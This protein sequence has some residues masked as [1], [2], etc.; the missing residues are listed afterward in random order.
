M[1]LKFNH[2]EEVGRFASLKHKAEQ[3]SRLTLVFARNGYGKSTLCAILRSASEEAPNYI[4]ARR[5]LDAKKETRI[6]SSWASG[7][8]VS[9][10]AGKWNSCPGKVY[11]FDQE[12]VFQNLHVGDSVTREN[13][14]SLLPVVLGAKG[15]EL[16]QKIIELD[17]EQRDLDAALKKHGAV[18]RAKCPVVAQSDLSSFC[19][20]E[21]PADIVTRRETAARAVELAKQSVAV[22]QRRNPRAIPVEALSSYQEIAGRTISAVSEDAAQKVRRHIESHELGT[23]GDRWIKYGVDHLHGD[24]CPFCD[25]SLKGLDLVDAFQAYFSEAFASLINDRDQA[26]SSLDSVLGAPGIA[27]L[28]DENTADFTFWSQVCDLPSLP[29]LSAAERAAIQNGLSALSELLK[30][31]VQNPLVRLSLDAVAHLVSPAFEIIERYNAGVADCIVRID[32]ARAA[33]QTA[34]LQTAQLTLQRWEA[35]EAKSSEPIASAAA[36]YAKADTRRQNIEPE[37]KKAQDALTAYAKATI[38]ARQK[39]INEL[40]SDFGVNFSIVDTR[41]NFVGRDPNT[42]YAIAIGNAKVGAGDRSDTE[43]SFKTVLSAGDKTTLAL[44]FFLTQV[45]SDPALNGAIVVFDDPF[46]S[47]DMNRQFETT[48][49]IRAV[50]SAACQTIVLSHDPRFLRMIEK[51]ADNAVTKTFQ[52]LCTDGGEGSI[53]T[54]STIEELKEL[55]VRQSEII[56][57][58]ASHGTLLKDANEIG[59]IQAIRPFMEDYL[60][61]RFPARFGAQEHISDM[62]RAIQTAGPSDPLHGSVEDLLAINEY[63]RTSMHGGGTAPDPVA[64]RAQCKKVVRI[65]GQ[66]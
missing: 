23:H 32:E 50:A 10:G 65:V 37:K 49:Q 19:T 7:A 26:I 61:A 12:F 56:R 21:V 46:N 29:T 3:F 52:L 11:V 40:L 30:Q 57:Q 39:E 55:Y 54:W 17:R 9:F 43:P 16:A 35:L 42:D 20:R 15:V 6:Q 33:V 13:K 44:A 28:D 53:S 4:L 41:A 66:Y 31:K 45:R 58:Y 63:T 36:E 47:Q 34:D 8:T 51:D 48:S 18:I 27:A 2:V 1:L 22:K 59:I 62:A 24:N 60:R 38:G 25:Q 64:L 5:R 14:R